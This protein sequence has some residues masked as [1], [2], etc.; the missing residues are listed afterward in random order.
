MSVYSHS[1]I[2]TFESCPLQYRYR[3]IDRIP[4]ER[5]GIE[6]F[7]GKLV[8]EILQEIYTDLPRARATT[9]SD[10]SARFDALWGERWSSAVR[11]VREG[12]AA[13]DYRALGRRCVETYHKRH[14]PFEGGEVLGCET[15]VEFPLD[16]GGRYRM[17]G[18]I[19]RVHRP[20]PGV[21]EIHDYK[22][23]ALPRDGAL[24]ADRQLS[25][26]EIAAREIWTDTREVRQVWHFL[27]H[28][29]QFVQRRTPDEL[30]RARVGTIR[31]IQT[32]EAT[33]RFPP[34]RSALCSWCDYKDICPE[35]AAEREA[36]RAV[37]A[38]SP[39]PGAVGPEPPAVPLAAAAP[40]EGRYGQYLLFGGPAEP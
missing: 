9:P 4:R 21:L 19:D 31:A 11:I 27:A 1:R 33:T 18:Y 14:H 7:V 12:M 32:I 35:W 22:T 30:Q 28:D 39:G 29:R 23:G 40:P 24:R 37:R 6:A 16:A 15:K 8:H 34:R 38:E 10:Q 2:G 5:E 26:Y 17:L 20:E 36:A 25:L 13:E 3:Y